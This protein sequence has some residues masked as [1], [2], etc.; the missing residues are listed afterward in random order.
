MG[1]TNS[2]R[3]DGIQ[4]YKKANGDISYSIRFKD[5]DGKTKRI[6]I[7]DKSKGITEPYCFQKRNEIINKLNLG[8]EIHVKHKK[9]KIY[10]FKNAFDEYLVWAKGNKIS[11]DKDRH[12]FEAHLY[13][14]ANSEL[15]SLKPKHFEEIKQEKLKVLSDRTVEYMLAVARQIINYAIKNEL[16]KNYANPISGG[17]V[18]MPRPDNSKLAFLTKD[19]A[20]ELLERLKFFESQTMYNMTMLLLNTGARFIEVATLTWNDVNFEERLLFFKA[21]KN[22]NSRHA[23]MSTDVFNVLKLIERTSTLVFPATN[24]KQMERMPKQWQLIVDEMIKGNTT[25]EK[26]R[27]TVHSLRHTHASWMALANADI[28]QI[29]EQLGHKKLD[30]TL[31]YAHLIPSQRHE[32]IKS[33]FDKQ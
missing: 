19:Q 2:K 21:T 32:V 3:Y 11:W 1:Y 9:R 26:Y 15:V 30:M 7:G 31:R 6:K 16:V 24:K 20:K 10:T 23:Y 18:K 8:E 22:G 12:L 5:A 14:L 33:I 4:L 25:A 28:L 17:R 27:I 29:K 13:P